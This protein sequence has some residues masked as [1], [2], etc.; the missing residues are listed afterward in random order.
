MS[1]FNTNPGAGDV[2]GTA[3]AP[4]ARNGDRPDHGPPVR[5]PEGAA[6][7]TAIAAAKRG[8]WDAIHYLYGRYVD[9]VFSYVLSIVHDRREAENLT[10]NI[11]GELRSEITNYEERSM[12]FAAWITGVAHT[13]TLRPAPEENH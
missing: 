6:G 9:D 10:Q 4:S 3:G 11:F 13:A 1:R 12:P 7:R 2:N 8:E 5:Q